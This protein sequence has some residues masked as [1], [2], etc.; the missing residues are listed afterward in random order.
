MSDISHWISFF[1]SFKNADIIFYT[2]YTRIKLFFFLEKIIVVLFITFKDKIA[3]YF[4]E[5]VLRH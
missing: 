5:T 1:V 3:V 2:F 4:I